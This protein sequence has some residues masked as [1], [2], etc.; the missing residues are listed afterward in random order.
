METFS[1]L[2][3]GKKDKHTKSLAKNQVCEIFYIRDIQKNVL[4]TADLESFV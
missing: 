4:P 2:E 1:L 3:K